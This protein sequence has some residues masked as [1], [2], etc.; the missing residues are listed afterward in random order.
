M[1]LALLI[2]IVLAASGFSLVLIRAALPSVPFRGARLC[3]SERS[4][5]SSTRLEL[6]RSR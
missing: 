2:P 3:C 1:L 5:A 6:A 4:Y